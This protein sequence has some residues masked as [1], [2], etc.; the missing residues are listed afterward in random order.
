M[1]TKLLLIL[2]AISLTLGF[3]YQADSNFR[4]TASVTANHAS[5]AANI[6]LADCATDDPY[7]IY[8]YDS[9]PP[10]GGGGPTSTPTPTPTPT[11]SSGSPTYNISLASPNPINSDG[12]FD[13][14][15]S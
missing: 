8:C 14:T 10:T 15:G 9:T 4:A 11:S 1:K 6:K 12:Y 2:V 13:V 5:L 7:N 3:S